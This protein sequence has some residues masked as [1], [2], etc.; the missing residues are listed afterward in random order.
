MH[1]TKCSQMTCPSSFEINSED[2]RNTQH[3]LTKEY[4]AQQEWKLTTYRQLV[5]YL[6]AIYVTAEIIA[7]FGAGVS[8]FQQRERMSTE[9]Y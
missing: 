9:R 6:L 8:R 1:S 4:D 7:K 3:F 5:N 2:S